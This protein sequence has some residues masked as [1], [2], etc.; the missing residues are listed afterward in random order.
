[1]K[2]GAVE[3]QEVCHCKADPHSVHESSHY[4]FQWKCLKFCSI[5]YLWL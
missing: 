1:V 3:Q 4:I 5:L 2:V